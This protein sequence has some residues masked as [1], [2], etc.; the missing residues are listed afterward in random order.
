MTVLLLLPSLAMCGTCVLNLGVLNLGVPP[1][2]RAF[3]R[4]DSTR[5]S[6]CR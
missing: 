5:T 1:S 4:Q 6:L 2:R 3:L